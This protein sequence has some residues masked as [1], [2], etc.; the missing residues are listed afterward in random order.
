LSGTLYETD[1]P[2]HLSGTLYET[3]PPFS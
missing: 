3:D 2:L 1:P